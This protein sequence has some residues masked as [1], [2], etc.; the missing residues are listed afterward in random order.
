MAMQFMFSMIICPVMY[1]PSPSSHVIGCTVLLKIKF[2]PRAA[3]DSSLPNGSR[4]F[5]F[6]TKTWLIEQAR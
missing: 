5:S 4:L 6:T 2:L 3:E 1:D